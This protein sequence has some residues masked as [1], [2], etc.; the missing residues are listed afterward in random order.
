MTDEQG[1]FKI[2]PAP[3]GHLQL[4]ALHDDFAESAVSEFDLAAGEQKR[5]LRL[6]LR[7]FARIKGLVLDAH[8]VARAKISVTCEDL[9]SRKALFAE[10]DAA[11]RFEFAKVPP[12]IKIVGLKV[13]A[14][15]L[16]DIRAD[17]PYLANNVS[18]ADQEQRVE[19]AAGRTVE[20]VL[21]GI[22]AGGVRVFGRVSTGG[23]ALPRTWIFAEN[24]RSE[25]FVKPRAR[26]DER[27]E[28]EMWVPAKGTYDFHIVGAGGGLHL[29]RQESITAEH[30]QRVD[31]DVPGGSISGRVVDGA[32]RPVPGVTLDLDMQGQDYEAQPDSYT[33]Y[34]P[35][36]KTDAEGRFAF[37][38][39]PEGRY[40]LRAEPESKP[41]AES[42]L[43]RGTVRDLELAAGAT[44]SGLEIVLTPG[45]TIRGVVHG[46]PE[47]MG[48]ML[49]V[50]AYD[51]SGQ[52][53]AGARADAD[54]SFL[55]R[56]L[57]EGAYALSARGA[58]LAAPAC[59]PVRVQRDHEAQAELTVVRGQ[60]LRV[61]ARYAEGERPNQLEISILDQRRNRIW[62]S[63]HSGPSFEFG[64]SFVAP[65][66]Y[67][68]E[69]SGLGGWTGAETVQVG[70]ESESRV[71][72][73]V[74]HAK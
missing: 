56:G 13:P 49:Y 1:L 70:A 35:F 54:G 60:W 9:D 5:D 27:G 37:V 24:F 22:P 48:R 3:V 46:A 43:A 11:G 55:L 38:R 17:A 52:V 28:Y 16:D 23:T 8:N 59:D 67:R 12:G 15:E 50:S 19:V 66:S 26:T 30:E 32:G 6:V 74:R 53:V 64:W 62:T 14:A 47:G 58:D 69:L 72:V 33:P 41:D 4:V 44:I 39:L 31:F 73:P 45:C 65:G 51:E 71:E 42:V 68:V 18:R 21:G 63:T 7:E 20:L 40:D 61:V 10:S 2:D 25:W 34:V 29:A 57:V 36:Y